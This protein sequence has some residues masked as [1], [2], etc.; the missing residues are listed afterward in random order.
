MAPGSQSILKP[1]LNAP[2]TSSL[3]PPSER[4][5]WPPMLSAQ[6]CW[7]RDPRPPV[8]ALR[9]RRSPAAGMSY[10]YASWCIRWMEGVLP[11]LSLH[12]SP[13]SPHPTYIRLMVR[14]PTLRTPHPSTS[15]T[16]ISVV[17]SAAD[18]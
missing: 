9:R 5:T 16:P 15:Q 12:T 2:Q 3:L 11:H 8:A 7:T 6:P 17:S 1:P 4:M 10:P 14:R 18:P 13:H